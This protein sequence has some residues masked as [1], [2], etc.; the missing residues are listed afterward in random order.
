MNYSF[1]TQRKIEVFR[2]WI[3]NFQCQNFAKHGKFQSREQS[4]AFKY[5]FLRRL[6]I[7]FL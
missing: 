4:T 1:F 7:T 3:K 6:R 2:A 5:E